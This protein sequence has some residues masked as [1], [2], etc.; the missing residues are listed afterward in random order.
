M[1]IRNTEAQLETEL[2][3]KY[4]VETRV[5]LAWEYEEY[6]VKITQITVKTQEIIT[7]VEK[8]LMWEYLT[9]NYCSEVLIE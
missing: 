6:D 7:E 1:R 8:K 2:L 5:T 9:K 3:Q 4:E